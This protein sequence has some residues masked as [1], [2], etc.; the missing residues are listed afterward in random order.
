MT[1]IKRSSQC[2]TF[3]VLSHPRHI[4]PLNLYY[5]RHRHSCRHE[6]KGTTEPPHS[7]AVPIRRSRVNQ[8]EDSLSLTLACISV[9]S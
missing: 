4:H 8:H 2:A 5:L 1:Q 9:Q 6:Y 7:K 3:T